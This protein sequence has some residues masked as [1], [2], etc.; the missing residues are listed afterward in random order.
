MS[1]FARYPVQSG[2]GGITSINGDTTS[3]QLIVGGTGITVGTAGGTTTISATGGTGTV[4]SVGLSL[5]SIFTVTG[6]PVTTAGTLTATFTTELAN[7]VFAGPSSGGAATP[8]FRP[9]V[10]GDIP[11]LP[12][13]Q[14][15][16]TIIQTDLGTYPT[17]SSPTDVLTLT[18]ANAFLTI[19]GN[20]TAKSVTFDITGVQPSGNYISALTGDVIASGPGSAVATLATVN[21]SPG[22][23][24]Y[25][26]VTVNAKGLVTSATNGVAPVTSVTASGPLASSGGT[27]PNISLTG[28]V[29][30]ANGGTGQT[31]A[32]A[33]FN[34][35]S[36]LTT[37]GDLLYYNGTTN[38]RLPIG[39]TN[40][41]LT[42]SGGIPSWAAASSVING[43][44]YFSSNT[45]VYG[46]TNST[47]SATGAN[48]LIVG[49]GAG[50]SLTSGT[51]NVFLGHNADNTD[52]AGSSNVVIGS[53]SLAT[54]TSNIVIGA[55]ATSSTFGSSTIIGG[56]ALATAAD[57]TALGFSA[58]AG[59]I[60]TAVGYQASSA[61]TG[62]AVGY[63]ANAHT[64]SSISIGQL[65]SAANGSA[66]SIAIGSSAT[67]S[68]A[69]A[70]A[71]GQSSAASGANSTAL[72]GSAT[73]STP[74]TVQLGNTSVTAVS[75][76]G[77]FNSAAAQTTVSGSGSG[78]AVFSQPF[79]GSS[80]KEVIIYLN[81]L[82]GTASYTFPIAFSNSPAVMITNQVTSTVA[83][84]LTTTAVTVTGTGTTGFL[85]IQGY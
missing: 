66:A 17:A 18:S 2:G 7:T 79:A 27:T 78:S 24:T 30:I 76:F 11:A 59:F 65:S 43:F 55:S 36:P 12:Y 58:A 82:T 33:A 83:T 21:S 54:G 3:N 26:T 81:A 80:Y 38:T 13:A 10:A 48:N 85:F 69:N 49:V 50:N 39:A 63:Q 25:A 47:L 46:G 41:I 40:Q 60:G 15:S 64:T 56:F 52:S 32:S 70:I 35:L 16:F 68:G 72:G 74:N 42:V 4:T 6:S 5:P 67:A 28:V 9:L 84:S 20:S 14:D 22:T 44:T 29:A 1:E 34:A 77:S 53:G 19:T 23:Y 31:T 75:T 51:D 8:T 45:S 57:A 62:V 61:Q 37:T 71:I 73:V